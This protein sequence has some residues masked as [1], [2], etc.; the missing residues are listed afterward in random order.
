MLLHIHAASGK[1]I[2]EFV[3]EDIDNRNAFFLLRVT[4]VQK[5]TD[6][7]SAEKRRNCNLGI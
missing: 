1:D 5:S 7:E 6:S 4:L 3:F 2:A